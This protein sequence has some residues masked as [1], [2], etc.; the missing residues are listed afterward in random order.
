MCTRAA[1]QVETLIPL[2]DIAVMFEKERE[3]RFVNWSRS[4]LHLRPNDQW[5]QF[6]RYCGRLQCSYRNRCDP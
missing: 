5:R 4:F 6:Y 3:E 1:Q 2:D